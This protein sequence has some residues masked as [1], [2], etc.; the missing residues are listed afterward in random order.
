MKLQYLTL[1]TF[2]EF[3][4]E[5]LRQNLA[6][7]LQH[8]VRNCPSSSTPN[9]RSSF[10]GSLSLMFWTN[11]STASRYC[12]RS[13]SSEFS[14]KFNFRKV[15]KNSPFIKI[16]F[17]TCIHVYFHFCYLL[18]MTFLPKAVPSLVI[19]VI[20]PNNSSK[21]HS[22]ICLENI[23]VF[24]RLFFQTLLQKLLRRFFL[25]FFQRSSR[26]PQDFFPKFFSQKLFLGYLLQT[27][28]QDIF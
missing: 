8:F 26:V 22:K 18:F 20:S 19:P 23:K 28:F 11:T 13:F 12:R 17:R 15:F 10:P 5:I 16:Y 21:T 4:P 9:T 6:S 3:F 27:Y 7:V 24:L 14:R 25:D 2:E 1:E